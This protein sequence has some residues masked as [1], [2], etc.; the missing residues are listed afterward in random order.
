MQRPLCER[1]AS[2]RRSLQSIREQ[3]QLFVEDGQRRSRAKDVSFSIVSSPMLP[4]EL[5][6]VSYTCSFNVK[7]FYKMC[8]RNIFV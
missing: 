1:Q 6:Y 5:D 7:S 3:H 8:L 4:V 2:F